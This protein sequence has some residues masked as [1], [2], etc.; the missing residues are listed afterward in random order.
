MIILINAATALNSWQSEIFFRTLE[1]N[2]VCVTKDMY[3]YSEAFVVGV[4]W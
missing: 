2:Y 4:V 1:W 3:N